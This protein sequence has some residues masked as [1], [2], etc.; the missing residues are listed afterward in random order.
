MS[1]DLSLLTRSSRKLNTSHIA[2]PSRMWAF[3]MPCFSTSF[4]C[5][6]IKITGEGRSRTS[7]RGIAPWTASEAP[8]SKTAAVG[9]RMRF[10]C[11][12]RVRRSRH[13][14]WYSLSLFW[15]RD[16]EVSIFL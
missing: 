12:D 5:A 4:F 3:F 16:V 10:Q 8:M 13:T 1:V 6:R 11:W 7:S 2:A 15:G 9:T 14:S